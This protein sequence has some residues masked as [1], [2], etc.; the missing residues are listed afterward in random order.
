MVT[1]TPS[2]VRRLAGVAVAA[3]FVILAAAC[4]D[5]DSASS[6]TPPPLPTPPSTS[7]AASTTAGSSS[8][9]SAT[10]SSS[11]GS[12]TTELNPVPTTPV[13]PSPTTSEVSLPSVTTL[14]PTVD[15]EMLTPEQ[16]DPNSANNSRPILPEHLPVIDA[17]LRSINA[18][19]FTYSRWPINPNARR[20]VEAPV[21]AESLASEQDALQGRLARGEVLDVSQ[22]ITFRPYVV[23]PVTDTATLFDCELAGHYW[24]KADTGDLVPPNEI[25]P[26][27]PGHI[28]ELG[29]RVDFVR[30]GGRWLWDTSQIDPGACR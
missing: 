28:V 16:R 21:T 4:S 6:V 5:D 3:V 23:G 26:A 9:S 20:L 27:G 1:T 7:A 8:M 11:P 13:P 19:L 15:P 12:S 10:S 29:L 18:S 25:W 17:Y 22:G 30:R 2:G 24:K 14:V